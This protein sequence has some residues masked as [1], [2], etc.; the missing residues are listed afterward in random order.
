MIDRTGV[1]PLIAELKHIERIKTPV[2]RF[3]SYLGDDTLRLARKVWEISGG[4]QAP[5]SRWARWS[6]AAP[7]YNQRGLRWMLRRYRLRRW[8]KAGGILVIVGPPRAG[9]TCLLERLSL[10]IVN[11]S[12]PPDWAGAPIALEDLPPSG[13]F[14]IDETA[15]HDCIATSLVICTSAFRSRGFG[16]VFQSA[17]SFQRFDIWDHFSDRKVLILEL[18]EHGV[19]GRDQLIDYGTIEVAKDQAARSNSGSAV[20]SPSS[21]A[22]S[23]TG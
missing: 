3:I 8:M 21:A 22:R 9:K 20:T 1:F 2:D 13:P 5:Y 6:V 15:A 14:A 16:L 18:S 7:G 4:K 23:R 19:P 17:E 11:N 10:P 12:R